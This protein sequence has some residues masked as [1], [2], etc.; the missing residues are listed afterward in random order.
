MSAGV[1]RD[2]FVFARQSLRIAIVIFP[3]PLDNG[4]A[5]EPSMRQRVVLTQNLI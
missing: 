4:G 3:E 2:N 5:I 1:A